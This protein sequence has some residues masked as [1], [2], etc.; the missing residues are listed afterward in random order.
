M[1][2]LAP[3]QVQE[4]ADAHDTREYAMTPMYDA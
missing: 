1:A 3:L 2:Y 4:A